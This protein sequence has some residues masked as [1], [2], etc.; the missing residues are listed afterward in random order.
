MVAFSNPT[1]RTACS[2]EILTLIKWARSLSRD[3]ENRLQ[4][5]VDV[6]I[7][8]NIGAMLIGMR[9]YLLGLSIAA[10]AF[11]AAAAVN[12]QCEGTLTANRKAMASALQLE[13]SETAGRVKLPSGLLPPG[14]NGDAAG[15]WRPLEQIE[16][17][18]ASLSARVGLSVVDQPELRLDRQTGRIEMT[19]FG[20][21]VFEGRCE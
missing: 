19:G 13:A 3:E 4:R 14:R 16:L 1:S 2:S 5:Q 8:L 20:G 7:L 21:A 15:G 10:C 18:D 9:A 6:D 12:L 17:A 11:P